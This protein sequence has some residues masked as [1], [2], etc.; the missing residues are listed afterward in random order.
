MEEPW[1]L[2]QRQQHKIES[3]LDRKPECFR[4]GKK[5]LDFQALN[6]NGCWYCSDC[7]QRCT[8]EVEAT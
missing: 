6:L 5:I 1:L 4:C 8:R 3:F 2:E 7:V